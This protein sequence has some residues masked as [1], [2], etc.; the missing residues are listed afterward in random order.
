MRTYL[1]ILLCY[2]LMS[3]SNGTVIMR[4]GQVYGDGCR[5]ITTPAGEASIRAK[6]LKTCVVDP[7]NTV[8]YRMK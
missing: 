8:F 7:A 2:P 6:G 1:G 4:E 3:L 5:M